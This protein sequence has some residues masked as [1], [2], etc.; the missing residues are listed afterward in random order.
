MMLIDEGEQEMT[1]MFA[2]I[3]TSCVCVCVCVCVVRVKT[4]QH[5]IAS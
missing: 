5:A 3:S 4:L 1:K 2:H